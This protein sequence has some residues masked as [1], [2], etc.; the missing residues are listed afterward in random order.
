VSSLSEPKEVVRL[1]SNQ[2]QLVTQQRAFLAPVQPYFRD[3]VS[4]LICK[5]ILCSQYT[6]KVK[7][8]LALSMSQNV[9]QAWTCI[10]FNIRLQSRL[11]FVVYLNDTKV[12]NPVLINANS[13]SIH[14]R[15]SFHFV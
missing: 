7:I 2:G 12:A 9:S 14:L 11:V 1:P 10:C 4:F 13:Q 15:L 8:A 6:M 5:L 3:L